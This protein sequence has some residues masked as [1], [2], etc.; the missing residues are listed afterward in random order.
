MGLTGTLLL[1]RLSSDNTKEEVRCLPRVQS[2]QP[3]VPGLIQWG[4]LGLVGS[5]LFWGGESLMHTQGTHL[6]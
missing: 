4:K 5:R 2:A 6:T 1:G 3:E